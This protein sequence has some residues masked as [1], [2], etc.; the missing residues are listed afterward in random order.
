[1]IEKLKNSLKSLISFVGSITDD[2]LFALASFGTVQIGVISIAAILSTWKKS[3]I[4]RSVATLLLDNDITNIP[5]PIVLIIASFDLFIDF[6]LCLS[7]T[8]GIALI[9][10]HAIKICKRVIFK[11]QAPSL[12]SILH[13]MLRELD[14]QPEYKHVL[15]IKLERLKLSMKYHR[16]NIIL[17][18][19]TFSIFTRLSDKTELEE[20]NNKI[21]RLIGSVKNLFF[22]EDKL[23]SRILSRIMAIPEQNFGDLSYIF[24]QGYDHKVES[25]IKL[26]ELVY[27][28][29]SLLQ[30]R[31]LIEWLIAWF[32]VKIYIC[33]LLPTRRFLVKILKYLDDF[34]RGIKDTSIY[35]KKYWQLSNLN[36][37]STVIRGHDHLKGCF[38]PKSKALLTKPIRQSNG[39]IFQ[40][41]GPLNLL[42]ISN[43]DLKVF[44]FIC[45]LVKQTIISEDLND[46]QPPEHLNIEIDIGEHDELLT[47]LELTTE[48]E[49]WLQKAHFQA[50][51]C[52]LTRHIMTDPVVTPSN[53]TFERTAIVNWLVECEAQQ[54]PPTCPLT[55]EVFKSNVATNLFQDRKIYKSNSD[56]AKT[57]AG[58][59]RINGSFMACPP[60]RQNG[61]VPI[62]LVGVDVC[63]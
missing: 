52:P 30:L 44:L 37:A 60:H 7:L 51:V 43:Y 11:L 19:N 41:Q 42:N 50:E 28:E 48:K 14:K 4:F 29:E 55:R 46:F 62:H 22:V 12:D 40:D 23:A 20:V 16:F 35:L 59:A 15:I 63:K 57:P 47:P 61:P 2:V 34:I 49:N 10:H 5:Q 18:Y 36:Y 26:K 13:E 6:L 39:L 58:H 8:F 24:K 56:I 1:M 45:D 33:C 54:T 3:N 21:D 38:C 32:L 53:Q 9:T 25:Y 17:W 27:C 31:E